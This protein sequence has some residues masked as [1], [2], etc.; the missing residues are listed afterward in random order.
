MAEFLRLNPQFKGIGFT[1]QRTRDRMVK[2]LVEQGIKNPQVL[3]ALGYLPRH[4]FL[5]EAL[6]HRAYEDTALPIGLGQTLSQ[7][8]IVARMTELLLEVE[9]KK[10][11]EIGA[12]SG[13]QAAVLGCLVP[14]VWSVERLEALLEK[15]R[16][17]IKNLKLS[18]VRLHLADGHYGLE[19]EAPF[20]AILVTAA[21]KQLPP[22]L[23][24]QLAEGGRLIAP[25]GDEHQMLRVYDKRNGQML[26][27]DIA[28]VRFVPLLPG[29][30]K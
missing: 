3:D 10:A 25:I 29:T 13:Y 16:S 12:G 22:N 5:D 30:E 21:P 2:R 11:L 7:P 19:R 18:N 24:E 26:Q 28:A 14:E 4:L 27:T 9:P 1:S 23:F 6:A 20:D 8:Y 17:R 15:A